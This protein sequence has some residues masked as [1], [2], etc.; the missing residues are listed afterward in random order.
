MSNSLKTSGIYLANLN[1]N[2]GSEIGKKRP[3]IILTHQLF[4]DSN[5]SPIF[6]CPLSTQSYDKHDVLH[7]K[8][9]HR[10]YL[11]QDSFALPEQ[12]RSI[13]LS[14]IESI[15]I[16]TITLDE[17]KLILQK[18]DLLIGITETFND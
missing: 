5:L 16:S 11:E 14:R 1:P 6:I 12:C 8:I 13:A 18:L 10:D 4:L 7:V 17:R 2:K 15:L 9:T 3:V